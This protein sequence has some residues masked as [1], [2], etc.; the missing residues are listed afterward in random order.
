MASK[1]SRVENR[2]VGAAIRQLASDSTLVSFG[3]SDEK[4]NHKPLY[5]E[6]HGAKAIALR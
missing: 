5:G 2:P 6:G 3:V 1:I 4:Y